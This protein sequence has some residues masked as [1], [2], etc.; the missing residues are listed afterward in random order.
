MDITFLT[1]FAVPIIVGICLCVGYIVKNMIPSDGINK[2]IPLIMG[3]LGVALNVWI[4]LGITPQIL[5]GGLFS[6]LAS[7][8]MHQVF[9]NLINKEE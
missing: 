8:G 4:N 7:T 9:K 5:L 1:E 2:Y 6:G 3:A